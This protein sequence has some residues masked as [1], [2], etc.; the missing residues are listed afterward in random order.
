MQSL[1]RIL[2]LV[3][4]ALAPR[5]VAAQLQ[6]SPLEES[7][8]R[9]QRA[10]PLAEFIL[11]GDSAKAAEYLNTHGAPDYA[12]SERATR[13]LSTL[14]TQVK[15]GTL[16]IARYDALG[17]DLV[18]VPIKA[19]DQSDAP[20][21]ILMRIGNEAPYRISGIQLVQIQGGGGGN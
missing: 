16:S 21:A 5:L 10:K 11:A 4:L 12:N 9:A 7:S 17:T 20:R 15:A 6:P 3:G 1:S 19:K 13:E 18:G 14:L 8:P 2:V